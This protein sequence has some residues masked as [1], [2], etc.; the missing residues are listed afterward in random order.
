M[1]PHSF[2]PRHV[3][4]FRQFAFAKLARVAFFPLLFAPLRRALL[5]IPA[6]LPYLPLKLVFPATDALLAIFNLLPTLTLCDRRCHHPCRCVPYPA[7][8]R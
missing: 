5:Q 2:F 4:L 1:N 6:L 7:P 3:E 8:W